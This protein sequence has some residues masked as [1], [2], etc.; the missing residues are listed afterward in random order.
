VWRRHSDAPRRVLI[1]VS[2]TPARRTSHIRSRLV[3]LGQSIRGFDSGLLSD[4]S[5]QRRHRLLLGIAAS[6]A[7]LAV[8]YGAT[9][10]HGSGL[11]IDAAIALFGFLLA[12]NPA[13]GRRPREIGVVIILFTAGAIE[14]RYI[15]NLTGLGAAYVLLL[16][17]YQDWV[18]LAAGAIGGLVMPLIAALSPDT[19]LA[20]RAFQR[21]DPEVGAL[22]RLIGVAGSAAVA[23][24]TW[25][26]NGAVSR[27]RLTG[28]ATRGVAERRLQGALDRGRRP[29]AV[30]CDVDAF[31]LVCEG[32]PQ[33]TGDE[34]IRAVGLR[35]RAASRAGD[36][37]ASAGGAKYI[38]VRSQDT[39]AG[40]AL[41]LG[42]R[43]AAAIVREPFIAD[44][45]V[46]PMSVS[47]G[48]ATAEGEHDASDLLQSADVAMQGA[49]GRGGDSAVLA[50][51]TP[52][53]RRRDARGVLAADLHR[54]LARGELTMMYQPIVE[55]ATGAIVGAEALVRWQHPTRGLLGPGTFVPFAERHPRLNAGVGRAVAGMVFAQVAAWD[56]ELPGE[57]PLGV[58]I[59]VSPSRLRE[60][61]LHDEMRDMLDAAGVD[62]GRLIVELTE[63]AV[64]SLD[65]DAPAIVS[66][67][68][69]LG[70][71]TALDDFGTGH[72]SL[73]HL[74]DFP[75][76]EV[77]VDRSFISQI[78]SSRTD[79]VV[80][81]SVLAIAAEF[82]ATVVVEGVET[83]EQRRALLDIDPT[84]L[85]QG[86]HFA[87]PLTADE[88]TDLLRTHERLPRSALH[89]HA[90]A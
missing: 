35:L 1:I 75:L 33:S 63:G 12:A 89:L 25:R 5:W 13:L 3:A 27:D 45:I 60:P 4:A 62:P 29:V 10:R 16:A 50:G 36:L 66:E 2:V 44:D 73:A 77:K 80:V 7:A 9:T 30:V 20:W 18:A 34:L 55:L 19:L 90:P 37:V 58:A 57:L 74:R 23:V 17:V 82:G 47:V 42:Q 52:S 46:V 15:G 70:V 72:S 28:L 8:V 6:N 81:R 69:E 71:R 41:A 84:L 79:Q 14:N 83:E 51:C 76:R 32:L 86:F 38:V 61:G 54:A 48:V 87:P 56:R 26:A 31:G 88:L 49:Q 43:L 53:D 59:N 78:A 24:L 21:E 22:L 65:I 68:E 40:D 85:A 11:W 39:E 64:M 67:L